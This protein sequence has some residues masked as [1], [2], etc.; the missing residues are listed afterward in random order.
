M[1]HPLSRA[2]M[3][4]TLLLGIKWDYHMCASSAMLVRSCVVH[5]CWRAP[6]RPA[7]KLIADHV[8]SSLSPGVWRNKWAEDL[9]TLT[10]IGWQY[11]TF[12]PF[13]SLLPVHPAQLSKVAPCLST[14]AG[15]DTIFSWTKLL[16]DPNII[17]IYPVNVPITHSNVNIHPNLE[18]DY[19][20]RS[21]HGR[22]AHNLGRVYGIPQPSIVS[23]ADHSL[24]WLWYFC[25]CFC[26]KWPCFDMTK[27]LSWW[28]MNSI[29]NWLK[30]LLR[31][32]LTMIEWSQ[33]LYI[34]II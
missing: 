4:T 10:S 7:S 16:D 33:E 18:E 28:I 15:G 27:L 1:V 2:S 14:C 23:K 9:G 13:Y 25:F 8:L 31:H 26:Q 20:G 17:A 11:P 3:H 30:G 34:H 22:R 12:Y 6:I 32:N 21:W 24:G 19:H 5:H 29:K